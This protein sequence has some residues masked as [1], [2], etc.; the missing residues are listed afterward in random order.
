MRDALDGC[1]MIDITRYCPLLLGYLS[2]IIRYL[3][4]NKNANNK[5]FFMKK[6]VNL[7]YIDGNPVADQL[8]EFQNISNQLVSKKLLS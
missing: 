2:N 8:N 5:A 1:Q 4:E 6:F 3:Y 7:K